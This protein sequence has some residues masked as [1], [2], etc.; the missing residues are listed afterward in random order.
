MTNAPSALPGASAPKAPAAEPP[1]TQNT[2]APSGEDSSP[3]N[4][5]Q[6]SLLGPAKT[7]NSVSTSAQ[8][9]ALAQTAEIAQR[10][11]RA[12][13][14]STKVPE[15]SSPESR[16]STPV[17]SRAPACATQPTSK[18]SNPAASNPSNPFASVRPSVLSASSQN[19]ACVP[20][21]QAQNGRSAASQPPSRPY[22]VSENLQNTQPPQQPRSAQ[23]QSYAQPQVAP[24][25]VAR[26]APLNSSTEHG[27]HVPRQAGLSNPSASPHQP[28]QSASQPSQPLI[29]QAVQ[30]PA[31]DNGHAVVEPQAQP[32]SSPEAQ[33][34]N[35]PDVT[36]DLCLSD[37]ES[38]AGSARSEDDSEDE[39]DAQNDEDDAEQDDDEAADDIASTPR[40]PRVPTPDPHSLCHFCRVYFVNPI[41][42]RCGCTFCKACVKEKLFLKDGAT[43]FRC[44]IKDCGLELELNLET[45]PINKNLQRIASRKRKLDVG[46][47]FVCHE[48]KERVMELKRV[49]VCETCPGNKLVCSTCGVRNHNGN[50][51]NLVTPSLLTESQRNSY[52][53]KFKQYR[54][55]NG[56][57]LSQLVD[58]WRRIESRMQQVYAM[59]QDSETNLKKIDQI[60]AESTELRQP[61]I[62]HL[63]RI[64]E[65][66]QEAAWEASSFQN[67]FSASDDVDLPE[68]YRKIEKD[69]DT[70]LQDGGIGLELQSLMKTFQSRRVAP[71]E[72][73]VAPRIQLLQDQMYMPGP[74]GYQPQPQYQPQMQMNN[75]F[76]GRGMPPQVSMHHQITQQMVPSMA[77]Q[78]MA[79]MGHIPQHPIQPS[80]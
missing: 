33:N 80:P 11:Q 54:I 55:S 63:L 10:I 48:C 79:F 38:D 58:S 3:S 1:R 7:A 22:V 35:L 44:P 6:P 62:E 41:T 52:R 56:R 15:A 19:Q 42:V 59:V 25:S 73:L 32:N 17:A 4:Q 67:V 27:N 12:R 9:Q 28:N 30:N 72:D 49:H 51:H 64:E 78:Q 47:G 29:P 31:L 75:Q 43:Y 8:A 60:L 40:V 5:I 66:R 2:S 68:K 18:N 16:K 50:N 36:Q 61:V 71:T 65:E 34:G 13:S 21:P 37:D 77:P 45:V 74:S 69:F 26:G 76:V 46:Y 57:E 70:K 53:Q 14:R 24:V 20:A 39:A 23:R